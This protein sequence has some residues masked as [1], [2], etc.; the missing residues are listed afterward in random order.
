MIFEFSTKTRHHKDGGPPIHLLSKI[1][2]LNWRR[3]APPGGSMSANE[4]QFEKYPEQPH[5]GVLVDQGV[6][7]FMQ[8]RGIGR[9]RGLPSIRTDM[10]ETLSAGRLPARAS[11]PQ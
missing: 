1:L 5:G 4:R 8:E 9:A 10:P 2:I 3:P 6:G 7:P 11:S